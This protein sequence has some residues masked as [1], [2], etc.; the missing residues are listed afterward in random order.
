MFK[1]IELAR[2]DRLKWL[3]D[4]QADVI[5]KIMHLRPF[6]EALEL[7]LNAIDDLL[8][9]NVDHRNLVTVKGLNASYKSKT[10]QMAVFAESLK[11]LGKPAQ[12]GSRLEFLVVKG[13]EGQLLGNRMR[14]PE[15]YLERRGTPEEDEIDY[16]YYIDQLTNPIGQLLTVAYMEVIPKLSCI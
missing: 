8:Q 14:L 13:E 2:R 1:G 9:G 7:V 6:E 3:T 15:T 10:A 4:L 12:P 5:D 11:V 16:M